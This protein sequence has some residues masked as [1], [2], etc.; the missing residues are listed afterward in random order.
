MFAI[1]Y[2]LIDVPALVEELAELRAMDDSWVYP[3]DAMFEF[4]L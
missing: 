3:S 2:E 4:C 1:D